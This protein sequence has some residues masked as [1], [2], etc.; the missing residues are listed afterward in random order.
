VT[1][2][3]ILLV[4]GGIIGWLASVAMKTDREQGVLANILVG[5][6]GSYL[7]GLVANGGVIN[8]GLSLVSL[9]SALAG[10]IVLLGLYNLARKGRVR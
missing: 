9:A 1:N 5:T 6:G 3:F 10:A 8:T 2:F 7:A 4:I